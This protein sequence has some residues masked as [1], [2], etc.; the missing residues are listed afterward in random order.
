MTAWEHTTGR[1]TRMAVS[2]RWI[3]VCTDMGRPVDPRSFRI[4]FGARS[5][6]PPPP[7]GNNIGIP[8][9]SEVVTTRD[10]EPEI[11]VIE[12][13]DDAD[14]IDFGSDVESEH[15]DEPMGNVGDPEV[16]QSRSDGVGRGHQAR[17]SEEEA[18]E[19]SASE[20]ES[21]HDPARKRGRPRQA[22]SK[23]TGRA[24]F[25]KD[26]V[27]EDDM[28]DYEYLRDAIRRWLGRKEGVGGV[29]ALCRRLD[30]KVSLKRC[31]RGQSWR[32]QC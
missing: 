15:Y 10:V 26:S 25:L 30:E 29:R 17:R 2:Y 9:A 27:P 24:P 5:D 23:S 32:H 4:T 7:T 3:D 13:D 19:V 8:R 16:A 28:E 20:D 21:I 1:N 22:V 14:L 11:I 6:S 12:D 31:S 18:D